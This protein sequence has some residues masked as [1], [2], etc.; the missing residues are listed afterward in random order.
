TAILLG[1]AFLHGL[2][3]IKNRKLNTESLKDQGIILLLLWLFVTLFLPFLISAIFPNIAIFSG[4]RYVLFASPAYYLIASWGIYRL[5]KQKSLFLALLA[6]FSILPLYAYH[7]NFDNQQWKEVSSHLKLN[8]S[9]DEYIFVLKGNN[10]MPLSYYY[11]DQTNIISIDN[12]N[13]FT[14][15]LGKKQSFWLILSLDKYRDPKGL[16]KSYADTHYTLAQE[17]EYSDVKLLHYVR[18]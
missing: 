18:R 7:S 2:V 1:F 14:A 3:Y 6:I 4:I 10:V 13:E 12:I 8:R 17:N 15:A 16:V 11:L 5:H 9:P